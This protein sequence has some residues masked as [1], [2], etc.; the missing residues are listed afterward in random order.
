MIL[1]NDGTTCHK[2]SFTIGSTSTTRQWNIWVTQYTNV[3]TESTRA[4]PSGCLQFFTGS[5]GFI[6]SFNM[7]QLSELGTVGTTTAGSK[8][9]KTFFVAASELRVPRE[10]V[11]GK[12]NPQIR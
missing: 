12:A 1:D 4:G 10:N 11:L 8:F 7:P 5:T 6:R 2:V 9:S 3:D